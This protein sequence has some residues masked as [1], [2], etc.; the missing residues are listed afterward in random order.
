MQPMVVE[1]EIPTRVAESPIQ[2]HQRG[3]ISL[4]APSV[5]PVLQFD[6]FKLA[7]NEGLSKLPHEAKVEVAIILVRSLINKVEIPQD[8]PFFIVINRLLGNSFVQE[9]PFLPIRAGPV[10]GCDLEGCAARAD[11]DISRKKVSSNMD[12]G[13]ADKLLIPKEKD[14]SPS[15]NSGTMRERSKSK[16]ANVTRSLVVDVVELSFLE[17]C[18]VTSRLRKD[19]M[20]GILPR[21][22]V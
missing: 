3:N 18:D 6:L 4:I 22:V 10:H 21:L 9:K 8:K 2:S 20:N 19:G 11:G 16:T 14:P 12:V 15:A 7:R 1:G 5:L 17:A 13:D